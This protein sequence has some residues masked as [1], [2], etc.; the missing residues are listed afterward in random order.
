MLRKV[1]FY[2][3]VKH[4]DEPE[5]VEQP[6]TAREPSIEHFRVF[7]HMV[8]HSAVLVHVETLTRTKVCTASA[9]LCQVSQVAASGR[10]YFSCC[11]THH[12]GRIFWMRSF[13]TKG[14]HCG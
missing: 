10:A 2:W 5:E 9:S 12:S 8:R 14:P 3:M 13:R 1:E 6:V 11:G 4:R 7:L